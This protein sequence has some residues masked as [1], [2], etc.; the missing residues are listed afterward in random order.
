MHIKEFLIVM[1]AGLFCLP[2]MSHGDDFSELR[3]KAEQGSVEAQFNLGLAYYDG[4][5]TEK[6]N[7]EAVKWLQLAA[8][9][10]HSRAQNAMGVCC[11]N[12]IG[13]LKDQKESLKW[14]QLAAKQGLASAQYNLGLYY[15]K[16][17]GELD[18]QE[19]VK[20]Y[21]LAAEQGHADAQFKLG[22]AYNLGDGVPEDRMKAIK[23]YR[24]AAEGGNAEAQF[25]IGTEYDYKSILPH[26]YKE[27]VKWYRLAAEQGNELAELNMLRIYKTKRWQKIIISL[28]ALGML[29]GVAVLYWRKN[30]MK[31]LMPV[32]KQWLENN[33]RM[34]LKVFS[35]SVVWGFLVWLYAWF[36]EQEVPVGIFFYP[37]IVA[38][39]TLTW[40]KWA[41]RR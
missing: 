10:G 40:W 32:L 34:W 19:A 36:F 29:A 6:D 37:P 27:A 31:W 24:L 7:E 28:R 33:R 2:I 20:W 17:Y 14:F 15:D 4:E 8:E 23:W 25:Q 16:S 41:R 18:D 26:D 12:G 35:G 30:L 39:I 1:I 38:F 21:R 9:K 22:C 5:N 11:R 3:Q 13:I